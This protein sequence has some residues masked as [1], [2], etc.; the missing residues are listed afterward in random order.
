MT[1]DGM[2][3]EATDAP[4]TNQV[5]NV[6]RNKRKRK[7]LRRMMQ[8][9]DAWQLIE[10]GD[11]LMIAVSGGK[12]SS[13][14]LDLVWQA[15]RKAPFPFEVVAVHLDQAQPGYE[16]AA[17]YAWLQ[18]LGVP[19]EVIREDTYSV[20]VEKTKPGQAYC[21]ICSRL[22]RGILYSVAER[23]GCNKIALGHHRDD[24]V[25]TTLMNMFYAG[26]LQAMPAR[27][28]TD[29]G[30]FTVVRPLIDCAESEIA[31]FAAD[32]GYPIIPCNLC[33]NQEGLKREEV[34]RLL[35]ELEARIPDVRSVILHSL[36]N[37][38]PTHL[39]DPELLA[40]WTARPAGVGAD[41]KG[42]KA[43]DAD[44]PWRHKAQTVLKGGSLPIVS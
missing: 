18:E 15:R 41:R 6:E 29:D 4:W 20:V 24:A 36:K 33:G 26:K 32:E 7:L 25:E 9:V 1:T 22:R 11:R 13:T 21:F 5:V 3:S 31:A 42:M 16:P 23:L 35:D 17:F 38:R 44:A 10:R 39:L 43:G 19:F 2:A 8:A 14:L 28:Q 30:R 37:V 34:K 27:Y 12:D 40:A